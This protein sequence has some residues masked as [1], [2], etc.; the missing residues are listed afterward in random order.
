MP[1]DQNEPRMRE[2]TRNLSS[3]SLIS[4]PTRTRDDYRRDIEQC[5]DWLD[6]TAS[7]VYQ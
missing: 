4:Y 2:A 3:D 1:P 7:Q 5:A 6:D